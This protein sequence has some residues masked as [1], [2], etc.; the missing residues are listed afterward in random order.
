MAERYTVDQVCDF[1]RANDD[2]IILT[3]VSP[4]GDT[5]GSACALALALKELG[6]KVKIRCGDAIPQ[7]MISFLKTSAKTI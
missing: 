2:F 6:K 7:S 4:D 3:H 1:L 5:L